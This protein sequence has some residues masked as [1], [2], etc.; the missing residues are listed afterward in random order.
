AN[1]TGAVRQGHPPASLDIHAQRP[2]VSLARCVRPNSASH[3]GQQPIARPP[4][5]RVHGH[6][7]VVEPLPAVVIHNLLEEGRTGIARS[8]PPSSG[9]S[10]PSSE[11]ATAPGEPRRKEPAASCSSRLRT[12]ATTRLPPANASARSNSRC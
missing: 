11:C 4:L 10:R 1:L 6:A 7:V 9:N 12:S 3:Q 5:R 2:P 8:G